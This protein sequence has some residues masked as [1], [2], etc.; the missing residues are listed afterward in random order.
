MSPDM[1][2]NGS[3]CMES[4]M[5]RQ[6]QQ[7]ELSGLGLLAGGF[8]LVSLSI[9]GYVVGSLIDRALGTNPIGAVVGLLIGTII[10][11]WDLYLIAQRIM[12]NQP[13]PTEEQQRA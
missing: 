9:G 3:D 6:R 11:F 12:R 1:L 10:G 13:V 8:V 7:G 2:T 5:A 4:A